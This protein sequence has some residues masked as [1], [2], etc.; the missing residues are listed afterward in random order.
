MLKQ[1]EATRVTYDDVEFA[2]FPFGAMT[3]SHVMGDLVQV[4]GPVLSV[5]LPLFTGNWTGEEAVANLMQ[6]DVDQMFQMISHASKAL[7]GDAVENLLTTLL[8]T[9][10]NVSCEYRDDDGRAVQKILNKAVA[11]ELFIGNLDSMIK[12]AINVVKV[13]YGDF[14]PRL[15]AQSGNLPDQWKAQISKNTGDLTGATSIL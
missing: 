4:I 13:N 8:I 10:K 9:Y 11:D 7:N 14:F 3:A 15:L 12:L 1:L 2:I 6:M 5:A